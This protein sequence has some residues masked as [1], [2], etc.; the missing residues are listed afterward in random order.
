MLEAFDDPLPEEALKFGVVPDPLTADQDEGPQQVCPLCGGELHLVESRH[1]P[2]WRDVMSS[3]SRPR[4]YRV[5]PAAA[6]NLASPG[7]HTI[8]SAKGVASAHA[9]KFNARSIRVRP[10]PG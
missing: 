1:K 9:T 10:A 7:D 8:E 6:E 2:S 4:W 5:L 3:S